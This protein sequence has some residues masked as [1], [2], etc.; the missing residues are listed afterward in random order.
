LL[1]GI[2]QRKKP[3]KPKPKYSGDAVCFLPN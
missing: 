3:L 2:P 1:P